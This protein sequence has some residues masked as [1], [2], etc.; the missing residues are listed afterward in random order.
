MCLPALCCPHKN[1]VGERERERERTMALLLPLSSLTRA[2]VAPLLKEK[3]SL[4]FSL[5]LSPPLSRSYPS[6]CLTLSCLS[7]LCVPWENPPVWI[8]LYLCDWSE[9]GGWGWGW[10]AVPGPCVWLQT[11]HCFSPPPPPA[12][13]LHSSLLLL[14]LSQGRQLNKEVWVY[15]PFFSLCLSN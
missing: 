10:R 5:D 15:Y 7:P 12:P 13:F 14:L 1:R 8:L 2:T 4:S 9:E 11:P 6:L 3:C